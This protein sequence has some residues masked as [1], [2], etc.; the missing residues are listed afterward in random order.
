MESDTTLQTSLIVQKVWAY[1]FRDHH[2]EIEL[3][4][5]EH[6]YVDAGIQIPGGTV[7][8]GEDLYTAIEREVL[9]ESGLHIESFELL[10]TLERNWQG[11]DVR[12]HLF[13]VQAP[14]GLA[15][16]WVHHVTGDGEDEGMHFR[17]YW[18]PRIDWSL[19][20]G[21]FKLGYPALNYFIKQTSM[22]H[23]RL[24]HT[25]MQNAPSQTTVRIEHT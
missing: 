15:D 19:V 6:V 5:F 21:D 20:Y 24:P 16:E 2:G 25:T 3:L 14:D 17:Y 10:Q 4:V 7:E 11:T 13:A 1:I 9:E 8:Q 18:L 12:A 23:T 22:E